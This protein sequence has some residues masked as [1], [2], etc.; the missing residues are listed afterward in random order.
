[1]RW[2]WKTSRVY[3]ERNGLKMLQDNVQRILNETDNTTITFIN[4]FNVS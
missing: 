3:A 4:T 2:F 1:M